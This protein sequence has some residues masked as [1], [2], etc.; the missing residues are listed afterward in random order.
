M[1]RTIVYISGTRADYGLMRNTL[2]SLQEHPKLRGEIVATG[3]H[4]MPEFGKTVNEI[5]KDGLKVHTVNAIWQEDSKKSMPRF[6]GIFIQQLTETIEAIKPD[7]ILV[8][9][10]RGEMLAGAIVGS[11][12]GIPV[13]HIHGGEVSATIDEITRHAITKLSHIHFPATKESAKRII[14]MGE[15]PWRVFPVGAPGL[16]RIGASKKYQEKISEPFILVVQHS[17]SESVKESGRQMRETLKAVKELGHQTLIIYPNADA[18][19]RRIIQAIKAYERYPFIKTFKNVSHSDYVGLMR[20]ANVLV[21]NSSSG[22]IE[23]PSF[24]LPFVNVGSRQEGRE[25]SQNVIDVGYT[26][27]EIKGAI[28]KAL[29]DKRFRAKMQKARNPYSAKKTAQKIVQVLSTIPING[30]LLQKKITY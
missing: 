21:G 25:R 29:F 16:E 13:A 2:F 10:D 14:K 8:M 15:E 11:Y 19:G 28:T 22:I 12:L 24:R 18:G 17:V 27:S 1:V 9:G 4:L 7:V 30:K 26:C 20:R 3:M 6:L 23:A 5:K